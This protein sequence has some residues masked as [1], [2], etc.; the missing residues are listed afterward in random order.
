MRE[1]KGYLV[2]KEL[3]ERDKIPLELFYKAKEG[4]RRARERIVKKYM[5]MV[6][7]E[8]MRYSNP[9][10]PSFRDVIQEGMLGL[11]IALDKFDPAKGFEFSTY[12]TYWIRHRIRLFLLHDSTILSGMVTKNK[13]TRKMLN[14][15]NEL[16]DEA[17]QKVLK[18]LEE[19]KVEH[20]E[21]FDLPVEAKNDSGIEKVVLRSNFHK[22]PP[23][24]KKVLLMKY[25][26]WDGKTYP[27]TVIA[28]VL[29]ITPE[30]VRKM[31]KEALR[32]MAV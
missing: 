21:N 18:E 8:A 19:G 1:W 7:N 23:M 10:S 3:N 13:R 24:A 15:F 20:I 11:L 28:K 29:G 27:A 16:D 26:F 32:R 31:E 25:G 30:A 9:S 12:A 4:D 14:H 22:V 6:F 5:K 2:P 17:Q